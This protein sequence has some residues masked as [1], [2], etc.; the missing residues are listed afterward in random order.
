MLQKDGVEGS[1]A[2][3]H[4]VSLTNPH[5]EELTFLESVEKS[6]PVVNKFATILNKGIEESPE[7][8]GLLYGS[9]IKIT[10]IR[11]DSASHT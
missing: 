2:L 7:V 6:D 3:E 1:T 9:N 11:K 10:V 8:G 4:K 5:A